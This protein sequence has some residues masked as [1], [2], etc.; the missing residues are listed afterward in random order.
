M[1]HTGIDIDY[2]ITLSC[3]S[4]TIFSSRFADWLAVGCFIATAAFGSKM[5]PHVRILQEF[6]DRFLLTNIV[7]NAFVDL[8]YRHS[9][10]VAD[11]IA[12][13]DNRQAM[14]RLGLLPVVGMSWVALNF[15]PLLTLTFMVLILAL[16]STTTVVLFK[17]MRQD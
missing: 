5:E 2:P 11:F 7:G 17:R 9:P 8:Y 15:G 16:I 4:F 1:D 13:H 6:R 10:A 14:V 12:G 3:F